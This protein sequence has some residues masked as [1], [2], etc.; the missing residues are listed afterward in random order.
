MR[1]FYKPVFVI[2]FILLIAAPLVSTLGLLN[3]RHNAT[4]QDFVPI[5]ADEVHYWH[6][7]KSFKDVEFNTGQYTVSERPSPAG[8]TR[9][10]VWGPILPAFYGTLGK[11]FDW[12]LYGIPI[13]NLAFFTIALA[14]FIYITRLNLEQLLLLALVFIFFLPFHLRA[15]SALPE[16]LFLGISLILAGCMFIVLKQRDKIRRRTWWLILTFICFVSLLRIPWTLLLIPFFVLTTPN[17]SI[18]GLLAAL[19]K[20]GILMIGVVAVQQYISAPFPYVFSEFA[21]RFRRAPDRA[22]M[23]LWNHI[24]TNL[25]MFP[26]GDP[27][28]VQQR[29]QILVLSV[30]CAGL[31]AWGWLRRKNHALVQEMGVHVINLLGVLTITVLLFDVK[32]WRD[33]RFFALH[34]FLTLALLVTFKRRLLILGITLWMITLLNPFFTVYDIWTGFHL[35]ASKREQYFEWRENLAEIVVYDPQTEN[36]WCNTLYHSVYYLYGP[37]SVL[38][39]VDGGVGL[40]SS[41]EFNNQQYPLKSHYLILDDKAYDAIKDKVKVEVLL[42]VPDGQLY[43]NLDSGCTNR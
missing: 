28:E 40:S 13:I 1:Q 32:E 35:D 29:W 39:A 3:L 42:P 19:V 2:V 7:A 16:V 18:R 31:G 37:T 5:W 8:F 30:S 9:Y 41:L 4:M 27:L 33:H 24:R 38:L 25:E 43:L 14:L 34:L 36:P 21:N 26:Q 12:S 15:F 10:Y 6:Q 11:V 17:T 20:A 22:F 23:L